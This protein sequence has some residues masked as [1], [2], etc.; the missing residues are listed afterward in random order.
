MILGGQV[1]FH[2]ESLIQMF[3]SNRDSMRKEN[4]TNLGKVGLSYLNGR[5]FYIMLLKFKGIFGV[6]ENRKEFRRKR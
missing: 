3:K 1:D 4:W 6:E 2:D 5:V